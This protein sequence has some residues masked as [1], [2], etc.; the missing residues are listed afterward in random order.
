MT[1][2]HTARQR[3]H[4]TSEQL[5]RREVAQ[6]AEPTEEQQA[7][8]IRRVRLGEVEARQEMVT[9][10]LPFVLR[11][12]SRYVYYA[13]HCEFLDLCQVASLEVLEWLDKAL[14]ASNPFGYLHVVIRGAMVRYLRMQDSLVPKKCH[15]DYGKERVTV[16]SLDFLSHDEEGE[17]WAETLVEAS[18]EPSRL[19]V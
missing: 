15:S 14:E 6:I 10:C 5:F 2:L 7:A 1:Q 8:L 3:E 11:L 16:Y 4:F 9:A 18:P 12:A 17:T 19:P 13:K